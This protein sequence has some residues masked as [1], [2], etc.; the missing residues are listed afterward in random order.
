MTKQRELGFVPFVVCSGQIQKHG[1]LANE[2]NLCMVL[3][4]L[5]KE[6]TRYN[7]RGSLIK[8]MPV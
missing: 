1:G 7:R 4:D 3:I 8:I 5:L 6:Q 2:F